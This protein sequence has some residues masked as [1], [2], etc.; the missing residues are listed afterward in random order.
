MPGQARQRRIGLA[1]AG[2]LGAAA[3]IGIAAGSLI[4]FGPVHTPTV[5]TIAA[6]AVLVTLGAVATLPWWRKIDDMAR[7]AHLTSWYWG[8]SI[9]GG[10][11]LVTALALVAAGVEQCPLFLG[12]ALV[13]LLQVGGYV[14]CWLGWWALRR[15]HAA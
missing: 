13:M 10:M 11:G 14:V 1:I 2:G 7:A 15:P 3:I 5:V 4:T 8:G 12:A 9:G 6:L